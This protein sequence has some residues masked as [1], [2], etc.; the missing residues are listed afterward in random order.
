MSKVLTKLKKLGEVQKCF[1]YTVFNVVSLIYYL[2][3]PQ[4]NE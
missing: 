3:D 2:S 1:S 4:Y